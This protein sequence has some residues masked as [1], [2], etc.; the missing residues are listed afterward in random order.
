[1]P[2]K[3]CKVVEWEENNYNTIKV[4]NC[5]SGTSTS[6]TDLQTLIKHSNDITYDEIIKYIYYLETTYEDLIEKLLKTDINDEIMQMLRAFATVQDSI[7]ER[8]NKEPDDHFADDLFEV[9]IAATN[10]D[11]FTKQYDFGKTDKERNLLMHDAWAL[12]KMFVLEKNETTNMFKLI[13]KPN[14]VNKNID[15]KSKATRDNFDTLKEKYENK[16]SNDGLQFEIEGLPNTYAFQ[17]KRIFDSKQL[18]SYENLSYDQ[19]MLDNPPQ[20]AYIATMNLDKVNKI[21][22]LIQIQSFK[23]GGSS[24]N[25][26]LKSHKGG[27]ISGPK[28][29]EKRVMLGGKPRV[30]YIGKRGGEYV[31]KGGEFISLKSL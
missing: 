5:E 8:R 29:S 28:P 4:N 10:H 26:K 11:L 27:S 25:S 3:V 16:G 2:P 6:S 17:A 21:R 9:C 12:G 20:F 18:R 23:S 30:V 1:M 31:K 7:Y 22:A 13:R 14:D 24:Y 19:K 15:I